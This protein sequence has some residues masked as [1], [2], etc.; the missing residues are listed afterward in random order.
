MLS[1]KAWQSFIKLTNYYI[2]I[3]TFV[4]IVVIIVGVVPVSNNCIVEVVIQCSIN[5]IS[6][7]NSR[8]VII[9]I[10]I[11]QSLTQVWSEPFVYSY[12]TTKEA[13]AHLNVDLPLTLE[14]N[15]EVF[16]K[17]TELISKF[18]GSKVITER[19]VYECICLFNSHIE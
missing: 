6:S 3:I 19:I 4:F 12:L 9:S 7:S 14:G 17:A 8:S 11:F 13:K 16:A 10:I 5:S 18:T 1:L 2:N 15:E